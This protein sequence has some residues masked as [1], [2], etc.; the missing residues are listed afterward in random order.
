MH[1]RAELREAVVAIDNEFRSEIVQG[2]TPAQ[3]HGW[4]RRDVNLAAFAPLY[5]ALT[6]GRGSLEI[7]DNK[8][9]AAA[10]D[11]FARGQ[12]LSMLFR[13]ES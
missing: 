6:F 5:L 10:W 1:G 3:E 7:S 2:L 9:D 4:I 8:E 12:I 11:E 13:P